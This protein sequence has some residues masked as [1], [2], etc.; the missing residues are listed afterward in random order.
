MFLMHT[1]SGIRYLVL[2][3]GIAVIVY[4]LKGAFTKAPYD[5]RMRVMGGVFALL[6]DLNVLIGLAL[7]LTRSFQPFLVGHVILM[8]FAAG[9]G[10]IVPSVMKRRPMEE[11]TYLPHAVGA[12][13]ALG[14]VV[15]GILALPA[16]MIF[17]SY[18]S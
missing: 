17:G 11:R 10:H 2:L 15:A 14:L 7:I 13:V 1:H 18:S 8:I 6:I 12:V 9:A 5:N 4:A 16:G 3:L